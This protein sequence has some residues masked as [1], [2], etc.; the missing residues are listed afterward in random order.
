MRHGN[1]ITENE[2]L[3]VLEVHPAGYALLA[4][5]EA[6][7]AADINILELEPSAH[8]VGSISV[9]VKRTSLKLQRQPYMHSPKSTAEKTRPKPSII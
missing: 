4:A 7:K 6:E 2:T 3:Y 9:V 1:F 8:S 5:N